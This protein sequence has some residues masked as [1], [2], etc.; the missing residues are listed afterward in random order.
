VQDG[1]NYY[2]LRANALENN[3]N[4][5]IYASGKRTSLKTA[6]AKVASGAWQDLKVEVTGNRFRGYLNRVQVVEATDDAY[7]AGLVGLWT[8]A[9]SVTCFD[10]VL[11]TAK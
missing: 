1:S 2:I 11:V 7:K 6:S 3:V 4:F 9:D 8:K 10:D 5:Y